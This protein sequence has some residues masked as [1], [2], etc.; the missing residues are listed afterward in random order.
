MTVGVNKYALWTTIRTY[1]YITDVESGQPYDPST[2]KFYYGKVVGELI[3]SPTILTYGTDAALVKD[4]TGRYHCN[5][6]P[7]D[8]GIWGYRYEDTVLKAA[9]EWRIE[10]MK[11]LF[12]T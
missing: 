7:D 9:W 12:Y 6:T 5:F 11:S 2:L 4:G 8:D 3:V 10:V 1:A